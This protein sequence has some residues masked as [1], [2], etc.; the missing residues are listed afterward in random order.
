MCIHMYLK[1]GDEVDVVLVHHLV[2]ELD[3]E[4]IRSN[5]SGHKLQTTF[6]YIIRVNIS[7]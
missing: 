5:I 4:S 6:M 7:S 3:L 2:H 1:H